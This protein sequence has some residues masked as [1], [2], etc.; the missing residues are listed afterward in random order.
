[1]VRYRGN[2][3]S[4]PVAYHPLI[5]IA[6]EDLAATYNRQQNQSMR[7][8]LNSTAEL[9][10]WDVIRLESS[11]Q[12]CMTSAQ[13]NHSS[14]NVNQDGPRRIRRDWQQHVRKDQK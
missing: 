7:P 12:Q 2:D 9:R 3:Y 1:M 10:L 6:K 13:R 14:N 8:I 11:R 4:V 5:G